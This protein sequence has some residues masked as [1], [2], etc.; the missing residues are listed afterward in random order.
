MLFDGG[1]ERIMQADPALRATAIE[2]YVEGAARAGRHASERGA[3]VPT[4][5]CSP[6]V[7]RRIPEIVGRLTDAL[8]GIG[9]VRRLRG[10]AARAKHGAQGAALVADGLAGGIHRGLVDRLGI[11]EARGTVLDHLYVI[12]PAVARRRLGLP[13]A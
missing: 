4:R 7:M 1:A 3:R 12:S 10:F 9:E 2:A 13:D 11:R 8:A 5:C 6:G